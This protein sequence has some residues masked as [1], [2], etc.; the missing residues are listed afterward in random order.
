LRHARWAACRCCCSGM[1]EHCDSLAGGT[2]VRGGK[3]S[4]AVTSCLGVSYHLYGCLG[5]GTQSAELLPT[6]HLLSVAT[7]SKGATAPLHDGHSEYAPH[8]R[9]WFRPPPTSNPC[10]S[11]L[12]PCALLP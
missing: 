8:Q 6:S 4:C 3:E 10:A 2:E 12:P 1:S 5:L 7:G 9:V 11:V